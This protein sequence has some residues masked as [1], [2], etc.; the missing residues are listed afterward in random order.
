[1]VW[2]IR[3]FRHYLI[4][5]E[6]EVLTD[7]YSLQ[8]LKKMKTESA[9]LHRWAAELEEYEF[10]IEYR[11]GKL[12]THVDG[13]SR[14]PVGNADEREDDD[15]MTT[16]ICK[17]K[18][19]IEGRIAVDKG[20]AQQILRKIHDTHHLS[21]KKMLAVF[22]QRY[23][24]RGVGQL[25]RMIAETCRA[26][27]LGSDYHPRAIPPGAIR[28]HR[29]WQT[30]AVDVVGPFPASQGMRFIFTAIDC[31]SRYCILMPVKDHTAT[32][33]AHLLYERII[34]YFGVPEV[35]HSDRGCEFTGT[36]W[37]RL[38]HLLGAELSHTS[39]YHPQG[40]GILERAHR[41][42]GNILRAS[43]IDRPHMAWPDLVPTIM[44]TLNSAPHDTTGISP[45]EAL[46]GCIPRLPVEIGTPSQERET[47][48]TPRQPLRREPANNDAD[49]PRSFATTARNHWRK[50]SP[51]Q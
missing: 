15:A 42:I 2:G 39:P 25:A 8:W 36:L 6:F 19:D 38:A 1:M 48:G 43:T 18:F 32:T 24:C 21:K 35:I 27:Q 17:I 23:T 14:F 30:L 51:R 34:A 16:A 40:N 45:H 12:Q 41:S 3:S 9:I 29:P 28:T 22:R 50:P 31:F 44:L 4:G 46:T 49:D 13:L 20:E 11:P 47:T 26:C 33:V 5:R 10:R 37:A 7:H